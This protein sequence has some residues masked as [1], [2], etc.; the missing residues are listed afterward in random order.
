MQRKN[1]V[2][3]ISIRKENRKI[4]REIVEEY[5]LEKIE[6]KDLERFNKKSKSVSKFNPDVPVMVN[7]IED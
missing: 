5:M 7:K 4:L 1:K 2:Q 3:Q 6:K